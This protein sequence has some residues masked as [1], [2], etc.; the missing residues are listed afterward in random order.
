MLDKNIIVFNFMIVLFG[1]LGRV[2]EVRDLFE[3][4]FE[5]DMV[6]WSVLILCYE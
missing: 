4:M 5:K 1:W 2:F 3:A 6:L